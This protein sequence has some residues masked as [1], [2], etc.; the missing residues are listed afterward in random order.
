MFNLP[1][2]TPRLGVSDLS[3]KRAVCQ[4]N[5][6]KEAATMSRA[7]SLPSAKSAGYSGG[8]GVVTATGSDG[9]L[10]FPAASKALTV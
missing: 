6:S 2:R 10:T 9:G 8:S 4:W 3:L 1:C 5:S 7:A